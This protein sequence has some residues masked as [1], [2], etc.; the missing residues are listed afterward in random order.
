MAKKISKEKENRIVELF[1]TGKYNFKQIAEQLGIKPKT[2]TKYLKRH[3][4]D[5]DSS[6]KVTKYQIEEACRLYTE[7]KMSEEK[8]GEQIGLCRTTVRKIL[9]QNNI[10]I[11][12]TKDWT[13]KYSI[14][15]TYF[16]RIDTPNKAY[17]IGFL[18]A[19]G[20]VGKNNN[21]IQLGLQA[22]DVEILYD[23]KDDIKYNGPLAF[24]NR[25]AKHD[26]L[27]DVYILQINN[28]K[29][30]DD[31]ISLGV[32]PNK[33]H[34]IEYPNY[35]PSYLQND[36]I[37][38]VLDGDGCIHGTNLKNGK[39]V[40]QVDICGNSQFCLG[41]KNKIENELNIHCSIITVNRKRNGTTQRVTIS[42]RIQCLT[43]LNWIYKDAELYLKRKYDTYLNHYK[44]I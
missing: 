29:I 35:I 17:F 21:I 11:R 24:V 14:D 8:I 10:E 9:Y 20:N 32:V 7:E 16:E 3:N 5:Y 38:G 2:V 34:I 12:E 22:R 43:F 42:G 41:L 13:T 39:P 18:Y 44:N 37:R 33:T 31:L 36:F 25:S 6:S 19:D 4:I 28:K 23:L 1:N 40:C 26:N 30:H 27:Q 15:D